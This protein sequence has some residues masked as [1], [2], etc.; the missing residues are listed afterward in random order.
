[1]S[2][3]KYDKTDKDRINE[4]RNMLG[5]HHEFEIYGHFISNGTSPISPS[6]RK[7]A[8]V[9]VLCKQKDSKFTV[10]LST[11]VNQESM[12]IEFLHSNYITIIEKIDANSA[13]LVRKAM[14]LILSD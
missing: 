14:E 3:K 7:S 6:L 5:S 8:I 11:G 1:M 13:S 2:S 12:E 9:K 10:T 4:L